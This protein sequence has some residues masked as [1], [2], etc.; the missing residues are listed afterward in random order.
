[1]ASI[2][3]LSRHMILDYQNVCSALDTLALRHIQ[4]C[5]HLIMT[6]GL[7]GR[8]PPKQRIKL[9]LIQMMMEALFLSMETLSRWIFQ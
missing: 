9:L 4:L 1:M 5:F 2:A 6:M 7:I 8:S 3:K